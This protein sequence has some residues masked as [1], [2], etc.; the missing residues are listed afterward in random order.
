MTHGHRGDRYS[1]STSYLRRG[2]R[3]S[4]DTSFVEIN[5]GIILRHG[6]SRLTKSN[7]RTGFSASDFLACILRTKIFESGFKGI[8]VFFKD[9]VFGFLV[10]KLVDIR[11]F[12]G[13]WKMWN[14]NFREEASFKRKSVDK[15]VDNCVCTNMT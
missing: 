13:R 3:K 1:Y 5:L 4:N 14:E 7:D 11:E 9:L 10:L 12:V 15:S 8:F 6:R 2:S